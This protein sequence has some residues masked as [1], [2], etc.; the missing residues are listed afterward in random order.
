MQRLAETEKEMA[1]RLKDKDGIIESLREDLKAGEAR[2]AQECDRS[3]TLG[4][5]CMPVS[6]LYNVSFEFHEHYNHP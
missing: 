3:Q 6:P 4:W 2:L 1:Q 5:W